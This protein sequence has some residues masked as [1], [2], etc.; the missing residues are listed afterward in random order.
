MDEHDLEAIRGGAGP[1][2]DILIRRRLISPCEQGDT[3]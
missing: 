1:L 3:S 2:I